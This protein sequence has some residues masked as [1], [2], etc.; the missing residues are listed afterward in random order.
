MFELLNFP[1]DSQSLVLYKIQPLV[2]ENPVFLCV[3][4]HQRLSDAILLG[5]E[6]K[7][8]DLQLGNCC[9]DYRIS[10]AHAII[11]SQQKMWQLQAIHG[12][13]PTSATFQITDCHR[14]II[15][16]SKSRRLLLMDWTRW[17]TNRSHNHIEN[18]LSCIRLR[19]KHKC[20]LAPRNHH[21]FHVL[22]QHVFLGLRRTRKWR[23][24]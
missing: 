9:R 15:M 7:N 19:G 5:A 13:G 20:T 11:P 22:L 14:G 24:D 1:L 4:L 8:G 21:G 12:G 6:C 3:L 2:T 10:L 17:P 16:E 23:N 18:C